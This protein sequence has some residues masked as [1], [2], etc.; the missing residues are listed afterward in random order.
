M[1]MMY[2]D[3]SGDTGVQNSNNPYFILSGI[4]FHE[5]RW[6]TY[7][8]ELIAFRRNMNATYGLRMNEEVHAYAMISQPG[9]LIRIKRHDRL[10]ILRNFIDQL[11]SMPDLNVI[12]IVVDKRNKSSDYDVF[13]MSWKILLQR[14]ENTMSHGNFRG[15]Q[16]TDERGIIFSDN[17]QEHRLRLLLRQLRRYNPVPSQ[18]QFSITYRDLRIRRIVEDISFRDSKFS[19]FIQAADIVAYFLH[20]KLN[21]N[22]YIRKK[23][24]YNYFNRLDPTLCKVASSRDPQGVVYL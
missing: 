18:P 22:S 11:A 9:E 1:Y 4:V 13:G 12:N 10:S 20:Q 14:F 24:G 16:N 23:G 7:L 19:Y 6:N 21:P 8:D 2:V 15:P 3:E 17:S 5:L